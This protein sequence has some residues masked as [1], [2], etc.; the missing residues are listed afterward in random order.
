MNKIK[1]RMKSLFMISGN[2]SEWKD[3]KN[4]IMRTDFNKNIYTMNF[5]TLASVSENYH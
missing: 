5:K 4:A 2:H 1:S 3:E